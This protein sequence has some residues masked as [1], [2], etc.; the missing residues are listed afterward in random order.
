MDYRDYTKNYNWEDQG[1]KTKEVVLGSQTLT[2]AKIVSL[3]TKVALKS[4]VSVWTHTTVWWAAA[5][6][7]TIAWVLATDDAIVSLWDWWTNTVTIVSIA[8]TANTL[9]ITFSANPL[10]DTIIQYSIVR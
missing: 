4:T 9:T 3:D 10:A 1:V 2:E 8:T 7:I 6:A 5:E